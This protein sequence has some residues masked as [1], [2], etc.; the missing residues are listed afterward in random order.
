MTAVAH[1]PERRFASALDLATAVEAY[2]ANAGEVLGARWVARC[3][4]AIVGPKPVPWIT[5]TP[6][7]GTPVALPAGALPANASPDAIPSGDISLVD[8]IAAAGTDEPVEPGFG[9]GDAGDE[10]EAAA[11]RAQSAPAR[12]PSAPS[13]EP[14]RKSTRLNSSHVALSRM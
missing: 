14:D 5:A 4:E 7:D 8:L 12:A 2:A 6:P 11:T 13:V 10:F 9:D 1:A 3:V